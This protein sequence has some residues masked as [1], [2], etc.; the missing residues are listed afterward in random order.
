[1]SSDAEE[2]DYVA[3]HPELFGS[4]SE[5]EW[6][7]EAGEEIRT[8]PNRPI[9]LSDALVAA[10]RQDWLSEID[11]RASGKRRHREYS[12]HELKVS[13]VIHRALQCNQLD[14]EDLANLSLAHSSLTAPAQDALIRHHF[15]IVS[16]QSL[17]RFVDFA[18]QVG[19]EF[20]DS[21]VSIEIGRA[22]V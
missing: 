12:A 6:S 13:T 18:L 15:R 8:P 19:P 17:R 22:H 10:F 21:L 7:D 5:A 11:V 9:R 14:S 4:D 1:M 3:A 16:L 20:V 2:D